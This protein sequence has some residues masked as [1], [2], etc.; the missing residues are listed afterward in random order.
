MDFCKENLTKRTN[1][2][3]LKALMDVTSKTTSRLKFCLA[4]SKLGI[5]NSLKQ[6]SSS[7]KTWLK[8]AKRQCRETTRARKIKRKPLK[9]SR[10]RFIRTWLT[11]KEKKKDQEAS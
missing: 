6:Q 10:L 4:S 9:C 7:T 11:T 8:D 1:Y 5:L 3:T 2:Y